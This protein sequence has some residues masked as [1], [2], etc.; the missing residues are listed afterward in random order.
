MIRKPSADYGREPAALTRL[1]TVATGSASVVRAGSFYLRGAIC[2]AFAVL[3]GFAALAGG[4]LAGSTPTLL[5][6]GAMAAG[7]AW[8]GTRLIAKARGGS[9]GL[10]R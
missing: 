6:V 10:A 4:F 1:R 8:A 2:W 7:M 3:W 9:A 5:G